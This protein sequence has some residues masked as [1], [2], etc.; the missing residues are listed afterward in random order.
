MIICYD[1]SHPCHLKTP[2]QYGLLLVNI[3]ISHVK[4][5]GHRAKDLLDHVSGPSRVGISFEII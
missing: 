2:F 3:A 1:N 5:G 4:K